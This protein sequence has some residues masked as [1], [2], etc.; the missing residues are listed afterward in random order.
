MKVSD[1]LSL[2]TQGDAIDFSSTSNPTGFS[3]VTMNQCWYKKIAPKLWHISITVQGVSNA[4]GFTVTL[5]FLAAYA[6]A[7]KVR[8]MDNGSYIE[9]GIAITGAGSATLN[10]YT[11]AATAAFTASGNKRLNTFNAVLS[12][13]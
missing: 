1:N 13:Q 4:T 7:F 9:N 10:V 11:N 6:E 8:V 12:E 3:S 5:P 2:P